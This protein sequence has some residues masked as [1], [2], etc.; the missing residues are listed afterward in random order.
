[1]PETTLPPGLHVILG[2][3]AAGTFQ[4]VFQLPRARLDI[5]RDVLSC[6]PTRA[7]ESLEAWEAMRSR[8]WMAP[9]SCEPPESVEELHPA[10]DIP[11]RARA[12]RQAQRVTLW[13]GTGLSEQLSAM[14]TIQLGA[15]GIA[16]PGKF[17]IVQFEKPLAGGHEP[18]G[19][20]ILN[21]QAMAEHPAPRPLSDPE[22]HH[23]G[24]LWKAV[25]SSD[26]G[27]IE[28]FADAHPDASPWLRRASKLLLRRFPD[29][30][31]GLNYW[32][33]ALLAAVAAD[34]RKAARVIGETMD[35]HWDQCDPVGDLFLF[36]R[37]LGL[38]R[39]A[40]P[41]PLIE[42]FGSGAQMRHTEV[43]LTPFGRDV[44]EGRASNYP[45]N[46][47]E[48]WAAGVK[49]SSRD[50]ALWFEDGGRLVRG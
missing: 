37:L 11:G 40:R 13:V 6:G 10:F 2:D 33:R 49:I 32:D 44:L 29:K 36:A 17:W 34:R 35:K 47:V 7:C 21:E 19:L 12:L 3:S 14:F 50:G 28:N 30:S 22:L 24:E 8:F 5:D 25:S 41:K 45:A 16:T 4:R 31:S 43:Q 9:V 1:M 27:L 23:Y 42:I 48:D 18:F 46:P 26:P 20:G 15:A 38:G 39:P